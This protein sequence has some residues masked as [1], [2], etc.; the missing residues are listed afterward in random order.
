M[1]YQILID[2]HCD[3][4]GYAGKIHDPADPNPVSV[5]TCPKCGGVGHEI[6]PISLDEL[7]ALLAPYITER[8]TM[9]QR[10]YA[11]AQAQEEQP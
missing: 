7:A 11:A 9:R 10:E 4:C 8:V 6:K 3:V 1:A 5:K 2:K